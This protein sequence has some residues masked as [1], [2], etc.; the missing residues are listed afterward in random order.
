MVSGLALM[1]FIQVYVQVFMQNS[2]NG[3][4][5]KAQ[6]MQT[7][8]IDTNDNLSST[9]TMM[10]LTA[11]P[12]SNALFS[13]YLCTVVGSVERLNLPVQVYIQF[14]RNCY[15]CRTTEQFKRVER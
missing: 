14:L 3:A 11:Y 5:K 6:T 2:S 9:Q 10:M 12:I 15:F 13:Q 1:N 4:T 7:T 8:Q